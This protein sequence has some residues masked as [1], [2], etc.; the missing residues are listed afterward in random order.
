MN[1]CKKKKKKKIYIYTHTGKKQ[2]MYYFFILHLNKSIQ[3]KQIIKYK[4]HF[5]GFVMNKLITKAVQSRAARDSLFPFIIRFTFR[6]TAYILD[7]L[8]LHGYNVTHPMFLPNISPNVYNHCPLL[9]H[10]GI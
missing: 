4:N 6:Q 1:Q 2:V 8:L 7:L 3:V 9:R 5:S 10:V